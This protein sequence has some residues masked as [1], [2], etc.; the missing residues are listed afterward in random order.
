[1]SSNLQSI[2]QMISLNTS[3]YT[4]HS[5]QFESKILFT[6][7]LTL[8]SS[9]LLPASGTF[10]HPKS[11][12]NHSVVI[13]FSIPRS[14]PRE[15]T[16]CQPLHSPCGLFVFPSSRFDSRRYPVQDCSFLLI[17]VKKSGMQGQC[18]DGLSHHHN[19]NTIQSASHETSLGSTKELRTKLS[20]LDCSP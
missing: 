12:Q 4:L 11:S 10:L 20:L 6:A 19:P 5:V 13:S 14:P 2:L 7:L 18:L 17:S 3:E 1:M 9:W 8:S 15:P 16:E